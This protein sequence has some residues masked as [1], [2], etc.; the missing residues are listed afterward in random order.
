[1][2]NT[3]KKRGR[4]KGG[5]REVNP[6][7]V[8]APTNKVTNSAVAG[9]IPP[10]DPPVGKKKHGKK[11]SKVVVVSET[12]HENKLPNIAE[13]EGVS[14]MIDDSPNKA[15]AS[16]IEQQNKQG[17]GRDINPVVAVPTNKVINS[18]D[19]ESVSAF[20]PLPGKKKHGSSKTKGVLGSQNESVKTTSE[21]D[22]PNIAEE[23]GFPPMI[24]DS[25]TEATASLIEQH[26]VEAELQLQ[27]EAIPMNQLPHSDEGGVNPP[28]NATKPSDATALKQL[29]TTPNNH[30]TWSKEKLLSV[31]DYA[32]PFTVYQRCLPGNEEEH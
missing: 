29:R 2:V 11:K 31:C 20:D 3:R 22:M 12:V 1:M 17:G 13:E 26:N 16:T 19:E 7:V 8:A 5:E 10:T 32:F 4:S 14:P 25:P 21:K 18:A 24:D 6:G 30:S 23:E 27:E 28:T 15:T 9:G